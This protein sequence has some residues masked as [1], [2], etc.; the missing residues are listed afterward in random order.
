MAAAGPRC[1]SAFVSINYRLYFIICFCILCDHDEMMNSYE[2][3]A[4]GDRRRQAL[5][6]EKGK[7][8]EYERRHKVRCKQFDVV[9]MGAGSGF[10]V[11]G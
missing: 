6:K 1:A 7:F 8:L 5:Q 4:G 3:G 11:P 2:G 9:P 10:R